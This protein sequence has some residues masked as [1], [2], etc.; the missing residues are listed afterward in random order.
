MEKATQQWTSRFSVM[1]LFL[2]MIA[3]PLCGQ[4]SN[5]KIA[6][7]LIKEMA[8]M[9]PNDR[10]PVMIELSHQV[11]DLEMDFARSLPTKNQ[12]KTAVVAAL[13]NC[14]SFSQIEL[15]KFLNQ[16]QRAAQATNVKPF[17]IHNFVAADVSR[18]TLDELVDRDDVAFIVKDTILG[19]E[20]FPVQ[21]KGKVVVRRPSSARGTQIECG[22]AVMG[23]P[24]VWDQLG[25][26]GTGI[27][28]A[29]IDT[30]VCFEH[31]DLA[32]RRWVNEDEIPG[33]GIDDDSNGQV[34]DING[35]N[36]RDNTANFADD[37]SHGTHCAGTVAGTGVNGV[38]TGMAPGAKIMALKFWN[39]FSGESVAMQC[40]QYAVD[41]EADVIS[42]SWGWPLGFEENHGLWRT[43]I[44]NTI[45]TG[46]VTVFAAGNERGAS[47]PPFAVRVPGDVPDV[48]TVGATDC[49]DG[50]A[51][52]SS[53]GPVTWQDVAPWFDWPL[54]NGKIKPEISAP[55]VA[56]ISTYAFE[57]CD[58]YIEYS[59]TSMACPHTA[60]AAALM[61]SKNPELDHFD[62]KQIMAEAAVDLGPTGMDNDFGAGRLDAFLAV[63]LTPSPT[64]VAVPDSHTVV[65]G[66]GFGG[67][68]DDL[69]DS[70]DVDL[71]VTRSNVS[72]QSLVEVDLK[73]ESAI[74]SPA[75]IEFTFEASVFARR[76]VVQA[77]SMMN[78]DTNSFEEVDVRSASR[79][80]DSSATITIDTDAAR[81]VEAGT[82]CLMVRVRFEGFSS[83]DQFTANMDQAMWTI[84]N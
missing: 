3:Q 78:Y 53:P 7:N 82:G 61:L 19:D 67:V 83:R 22:V 15:L 2:A 51:D 47:S 38:Q 6:P 73:T 12:R 8:K 55:G 23:A 72:V 75:A 31:P 9:G 58:G 33:N 39:S 57:G 59:G 60:G 76:D 17:W 49:S 64:I 43:V 27:T 54:P 65:S 69:E 81:F 66:N 24:A 34:D 20:L 44:E 25:F 13:K 18:N 37:N 29:V 11:T 56:T 30:G 35:W 41:N 45:A 63:E 1:L 80:S 16:K 68:T 28:V 62:V 50:L 79:F 70:D 32:S 36:F 14:A 5:E 4:D 74:E 52:F 26:D 46:M 21:P 48:I 71:S 42:A 84:S 40:V 77:I 10:V